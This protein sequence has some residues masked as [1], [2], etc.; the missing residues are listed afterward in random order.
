MRPQRLSRRTILRSSMV[1][2]A[3]FAVPWLVTPRTSYGLAKG[4][5]PHSEVDGLRAVGVHDPDMVDGRKVRSSWK[6]QE[7]MIRR[8]RV[9]ENLDRMACALTGEDEP[10]RAWRG[11]FLK[12]PGKPWSDVVVAIKTNQNGAQHGH[13]AVLGKV[14]R[15]LTD[16]RGVRG[17]NIH[18][19]DACH[20]KDMPQVTPYSGLPEGVHLESRWGGYNTPVPVPPP[21]RDGK[22]ELKCLD[23]LARGDVD[24]LVNLNVS[25]GT[26]FRYGNYSQATKN[27]LGTFNPLPS[28]E[29]DGGGDY[30][31]SVNRAS[32]VLG[33]VDEETGEVLFPRQQ[34]AIIDALWSSE[35]GPM[36]IPSAQSERLFMGT[37]PPALDYQVATEF[38]R[39]QMGWR[40]NQEVTDR[41][42]SDYGFR[43]SDLPGDGTII[44]AREATS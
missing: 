12:P 41:L 31:V 8:G 34:L 30:L 40:I 32:A 36:V 26:L 25:R 19:Y 15:V 9:E 21:W 10:G 3:G 33:D 29:D 16:I 35:Q 4:T 22:A 43:P 27:H 6:E 13:S 17:D 37:F 11:V 20:G 18:L 24:I 44:D 14:C 1:G 7:Q 2:A 5:T 28:H 23:P 38:R 39:D 42:L